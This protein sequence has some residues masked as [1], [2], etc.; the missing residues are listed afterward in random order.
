M[1]TEIR[2]RPARFRWVRMKTIKPCKTW[3][4]SLS[5][6]KPSNK[7]KTLNRARLPV[8]AHPK[9]VHTSTHRS[10]RATLKVAVSVAARLTR[11]CM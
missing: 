2:M 11:T 1:K 6:A 10:L 7:N 9:S 3:S 5:R 8:R 4:L